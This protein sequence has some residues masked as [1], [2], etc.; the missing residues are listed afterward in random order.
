MSE[1][2]RARARS[3]RR[4]NTDNITDG[5]NAAADGSSGQH[6]NVGQAGRNTGVPLV[7]VQTHVGHSE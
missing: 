7:V 5:S 6:T 3:G 2:V 4:A 1:A